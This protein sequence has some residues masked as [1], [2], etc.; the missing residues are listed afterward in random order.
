MPAALFFCAAMGKVSRRA[1]RARTE[2]RICQ[3]G[4]QTRPGRLYHD[5]PINRPNHSL[6]KTAPAAQWCMRRFC[7]L[8]SGRYRD[9]S[10]YPRLQRNKNRAAGII[11]VMAAQEGRKNSKH[12]SK[13]IC[14]RLI[15]RLVFIS[16]N[17]SMNKHNACCHRCHF[18]QECDIPFIVL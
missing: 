7:A 14:L 18:L 3:C 17:P 2:V 4:T 11:C 6:K 16:A 9:A 1:L 8:L 15:R 13:V 12:M 10:I 5:L